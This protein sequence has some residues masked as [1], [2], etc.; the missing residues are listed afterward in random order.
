MGVITLAL[1]LTDNAKMGENGAAATVF[2]LGYA[3]TGLL[4]LCLAVILFMYPDGKYII[5]AG[6]AEMFYLAFCWTFNGT[7]GLFS[8]GTCCL[9][10]PSPSHLCFCLW[11]CSSGDLVRG[12]PAL[13]YLYPVRD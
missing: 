9:G 12:N 3:V 8:L 1:M 10:D 2:P 6:C 5:G 4:A 7:S 11:R 13:E